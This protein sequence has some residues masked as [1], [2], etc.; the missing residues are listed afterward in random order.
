VGRGAGAGS[1]VLRCQLSRDLGQKEGMLP[2][3]EPF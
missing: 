2:L 1:K 3:R